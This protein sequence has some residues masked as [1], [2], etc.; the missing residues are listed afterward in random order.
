[1]DGDRGNTWD[2]GF[3]NQSSSECP[4]TDFGFIIFEIGWNFDFCNFPLNLM[5]QVTDHKMDRV[6]QCFPVT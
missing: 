6:M 5:L 2:T 4:E 3:K 1:M